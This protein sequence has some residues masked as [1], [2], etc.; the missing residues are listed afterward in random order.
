[1]LAAFLVS[2]GAMFRQASKTKP[3][4]KKN[5]VFMNCAPQI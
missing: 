2:A 3:A 1:M 4:K 5:L